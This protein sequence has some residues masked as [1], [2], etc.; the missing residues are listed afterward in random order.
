MMI[1]GATN[2]LQQIQ[3]CSVEVKCLIGETSPCLTSVFLY[4]TNNDWEVNMDTWM[5]Q[6]HNPL[7]IRNTRE[8][9]LS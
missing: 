2:A 4:F 1:F 9:S 5:I 6:F 8:F 7:E 3:D